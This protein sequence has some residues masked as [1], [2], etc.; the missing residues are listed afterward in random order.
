MQA[1]IKDLRTALKVVVYVNSGSDAIQ[2]IFDNNPELMR[3]LFSTV[4]IANA[5]FHTYPTEALFYALC[6]QFRSPNLTIADKDGVIRQVKR[7][8]GRYEG[9]SSIFFKI[10][11][12]CR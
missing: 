1:T 5:L 11:E 7:K 4:I 10:F 6:G 3:K 8:Q 12:G 2:V 9:M